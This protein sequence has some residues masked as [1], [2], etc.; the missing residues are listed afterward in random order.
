MRLSVTIA[1]LVAALLGWAAWRLQP[2]LA[3]AAGLTSHELCDGVFIADQSS[4][5]VFRTNLVPRQGYHW[6]AWA[7]RY[8]VD[9]EQ[10]SV[11]SS[12]LGAF[13][14]TAVYRKG[15]GCL[16]LHGTPPAEQNASLPQ[17][18]PAL[19][20]PLA[21]HGVVAP[22][23]AKLKTA[24]DAEFD[25]P[26][27]RTEAVVVVHDGHIIAE[28]YAPG[29]G[30]RTPL[31][32][33]SATKSVISALIGILVREK[34]LSLYGPAPVALWAAGGDKR[35]AISID[36]LLRMRSGLDFPETDSG[37]G[38]PSR[39]LFLQ[40]NMAAY[41]ERTRLEFSPG[42]V[43]S[44][45]SASYLILSQ[46]LRNAVGGGPAQVLAFAHRELFA[47]LGMTNVHLDFDATGTPVG[48]TYML[49][50]ARSWARFGMLYLDDGVVGGQ[51]MLPAGW[52]RY[53]T[54]PSP[55]TGYGAGFWTERVGKGANPWKWGLPDVPA[56][57]FM[58]RGILGQFVVVVPSK[59][60]VVVRFGL[61]DETGPNVNDSQGMGRLV[62]AVI[63]AIAGRNSSRHV[64]VASNH[65]GSSSRVSKT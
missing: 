28:R 27:R 47:P 62:A 46:I 59:D 2:A 41:A 8:K 58:A 24:L 42:T 43:W 40:R 60:L 16:V 34:K 31:I 54:T 5:V 22:V 6:I 49:A 64:P 9:R 52:V 10:A 18:G 33:Y 65:V 37:L 30:P 25:G 61:T 32:G 1:S 51:R 23:N 11:T 39:M 29:I 36:D 55:G 44:Y 19:L 14:A 13:S 35:H 26:R 20:P 15:F 21:G 45:S 53:S 17:D 48:S 3:V 57:T 50:P 7:I 4:Q 63:A 38:R 56:D 12:L